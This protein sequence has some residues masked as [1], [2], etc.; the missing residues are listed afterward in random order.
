MAGQPRDN[1]DKARASA[2]R[3]K[4]KLRL[5]AADQPSRRLLLPGESSC[6]RITVQ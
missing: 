3:A 6:Q 1:P 2:A 5:V 4:H